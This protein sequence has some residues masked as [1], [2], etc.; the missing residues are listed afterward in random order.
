MTD[1]VSATSVVYMG[2]PDFAVPALAALC[3]AGYNIP[4][5]VTQPDRPRGRGHR[6]G[7]SPVKEDALRRGLPVLQ[8]ESIRG[9]EGFAETLRE[10]APCLIAVAA[11]GK[12]LP[13]EILEIPTFG[14]INIHASILPRYRGA[15][16]IHRAI[17]AGES[18]TGVSLL[19][20]SEGLDEGDVFAVRTLDLDGH[21]TGSATEALAHIGAAL[22]LETLPA[23]AAGTAHRTPQDHG[24]SSYAPPVAKGEGHVDFAAGMTASVRKVRAMNPRPG[25]FA[26]LDGT[27]VRILEARACTQATQA[28]EARDDAPGTIL[29][30]SADGIFVKASDGVVVVSKVQ[31][32]GKGPVSVADYLRGNSVDPGKRFE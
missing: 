10:A 27:K 16:P 11:Y 17:E 5:V 30:A 26:V 7:P 29:R 15:A 23:I 25:A 19:A 4:F 1:N 32:P 14:C 18:E 3:E 8:P 31:M 28:T 2:T 13:R 20:M 22:L 12:I 24:S 9:D 6:T 21:D